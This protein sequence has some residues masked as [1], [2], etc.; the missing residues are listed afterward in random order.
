[1]A[2]ERLRIG[3]VGAGDVAHRH[4]LPGLA[5]MADEIRLVAVA[6]PKRGAPEAL[7]KAASSW[8]PGTRAW[9]DA[10]E[11]LARERLDGVFNLTPATLQGPSTGF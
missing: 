1:M 2:R 8:S 4:Y 10:P 7:A 3:V 9:A 11:M 6:D 5:A